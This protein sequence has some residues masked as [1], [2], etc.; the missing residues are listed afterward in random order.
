MRPVTD[1]TPTPTRPVTSI[2]DKAIRPLI[3][4]APICNAAEDHT[5]C[6]I[7]EENEEASRSLIK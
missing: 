4:K 5:A 3:P 2:N 7:D 1:T 6:L